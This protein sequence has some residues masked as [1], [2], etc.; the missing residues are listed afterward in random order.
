M[1]DN[2][3]TG[4]GKRGMVRTGTAA[5]G[6]ALIALALAESP[7]GATP[8][9]GR[10]T[11][12]VEINVYDWG[13]VSRGKA[14]SYDTLVGEAQCSFYSEQT[15][16]PSLS[17]CDGVGSSDEDDD[18]NFS[19]IECWTKDGD[20]L[21]ADILKSSSCTPYSC[22][23]VNGAILAGC[24][25]TTSM[26]VSLTDSSGEGIFADAQGAFTVTGS[27]TYGTS[28]TL[29][30][31]TYYTASSSGDIEGDLTLAGGAPPDGVSLDIPAPGSTQSGI[32][33][34]S[35][36]SCLDGHLEATFSEA[37]GTPLSTWTIPHGASRGDTHDRCGD[38]DNGFSMPMNWYLLGPGEKTLTLFVNGKERVTRNFSV[39]TFGQEFVTDAGGTCT[40]VDFRDSQNATFVWQQA[41]QGL[42]LE[43]LN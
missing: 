26:E 33:L 8:Y 12:T 32:G 29:S 11:G 42:V 14:Y 19:H 31:F 28:R 15:L 23:D 20:L 4:K 18:D 17:G 40:I 13:S 2:S 1:R 27:L 39:T 10:T 41:N 43:S 36:W 30:S 37:D 24:T 25:A 5:L 3:M 38:S 34:V 6:C 16:N 21:Y 35:G 22:F 9:T 7:V